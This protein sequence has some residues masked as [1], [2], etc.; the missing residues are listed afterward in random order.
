[1][2]ENNRF[3]TLA[4]SPIEIVSCNDTRYFIHKR[5]FTWDMYV[6]RLPCSEWLPA[7]DVQVTREILENYYPLIPGDTEP[8]GGI[9]GGIAEA[10]YGGVPEYI[11]AQALSLLPPELI[12][13]IAQFSARYR[14][15]L[16]PRMEKD[17]K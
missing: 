14:G 16:I 2:K 10:Y 5:L 17:D 11:A 9:T 7:R 12:R 1:M 15:K 4:E 6:Y 13:V 3:Y 8:A